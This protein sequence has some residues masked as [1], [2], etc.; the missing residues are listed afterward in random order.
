[1][2]SRFR[3]ANTATAAA[4]ALLVV[5]SAE[6]L[7]NCADVNSGVFD[8]SAYTPTGSGILDTSTGFAVG[9]EITFIVS[10]LPGSS[11]EL[12]NGALDTA[13]LVQPLSA[14]QATVT[15]T[16]TGENEDTTLSTYMLVQA[17]PYEITVAAT[18]VPAD[19]GGGPEATVRSFMTTRMSSILLDSPA[20]TSLRNRID[21]TEG[22][23]T[24][25]GAFSYTAGDGPANSLRFQQSLSALRLQAARAA[26]GIAP[27]SPW[28]IWMA[29]RFS[30]FDIDGGHEGHVGLL[31]F[32]GD[33]R[34]SDRLLVGMMAEFDWAKEDNATLDSSVDGNGWMAGPYLSAR[35]HDAIFFDLRAAWGQSSNS[36]NAGGAT[37]EFDTDRWLVKGTVS[38]NWTNGGWRFTPS[39]D[40]AYMSERAG[41][42]TDSTY[43]VI[44]AQEVSLGRLQIGPEIG[45]RFGDASGV[46]VEPFAAVKGVWDFHDDSA[47]LTG[48]S[49]WWGRLQGG[50]NLQSA[51]GLRVS[52]LV[53]WDGLGAK[54]REGYSIRGS[55]GVPL[56]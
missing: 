47:A 48:D 36:L 53:S 37:G 21:G 4:V 54:G 10:G 16:V 50:I 23:S 13:L 20:A 12:I 42:F 9:D 1:M 38:G 7:A 5:T 56:N 45:Y 8:R 32:G 2:L 29:G 55:L 43:T 17:I 49:Q 40:L 14:T 25:P 15:Y 51:G 33:Y 44:P 34:V 39:A 35:I 22:G 11:F 41:A 52:G 31:S 24:L 6:A 19:T 3:S 27:P 30:A 26:G 18:C 28:D 46:S